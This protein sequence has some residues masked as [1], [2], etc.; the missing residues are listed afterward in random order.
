M[1]FFML[2]IK[3]VK[4]VYIIELAIAAFLLNGSGGYLG[5]RETRRLLGVIWVF[6]RLPGLCDGIV[7]ARLPTLRL[8][9]CLSI[10]KSWMLSWLRVA[11]HLQLLS[12]LVGIYGSWR[13]LCSVKGEERP[14]N[15][16]DWISAMRVLVRH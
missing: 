16:T 1:C 12:R 9:R 14:T 6:M 11:G 3:D 10:T 13:K 7:L 8:E 4:D 15:S 5:Y 2:S